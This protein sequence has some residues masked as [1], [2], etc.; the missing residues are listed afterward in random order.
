MRLSPFHQLLMTPN[1]DM[2]IKIKQLGRLKATSV[3][4]TVSKRCACLSFLLWLFHFQVR[5][6]T[7]MH[8]ECVQRVRIW[9]TAYLV[10]SSKKCWKIFLSF[11]S[12]ECC[13]GEICD[14]PIKMQTFSTVLTFFPLQSFEASCQVLCCQPLSIIL[15]FI[16]YEGC[17]LCSHAGANGGLLV[18]PGHPVLQETRLFSG[19]NQTHVDIETSAPFQTADCQT[20]QNFTKKLIVGRTGEYH[21]APHKKA[22]HHSL[23]YFMNIN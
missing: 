15:L 1:K 9:P 21:G 6:L 20:S 17:N 2:C 10:F 4:T 13:L 22:G 11:F 23:L 5:C 16:S 19:Y 14:M 12:N 18:H 7:H 8:F 3:N